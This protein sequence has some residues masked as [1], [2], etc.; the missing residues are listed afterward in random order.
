MT[1]AI[2][3]LRDIHLPPSPGWWPPAPGWWVVAASLLI[4]MAWTTRRMLHAR[5]RHHRIRNALRDYDTALAGAHQASAKIA[6]ASLLLRRAAKARDAGA[7][8]LEGDAWLHFLDGDD[9]TQPFS[10]GV[11]RLLRDGGFRRDL[12]DDIA[13]ALTLARRRFAALLERGDA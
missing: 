8:M 9:A 11:G 1:G 4:A 12:A 5:S 13:P 10:D 3:A 7:A 2:S 6:A